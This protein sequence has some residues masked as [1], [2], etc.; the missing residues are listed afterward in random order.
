MII[1][2]PSENASIIQG[3]YCSSIF[4]KEKAV[5]DAKTVAGYWAY[6]CMKH[7]RSEGTSNPQ[8]INNITTAPLEIP[9]IRSKK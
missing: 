4:C 2:Q 8:L 9:W 1:L 3:V 6:L 7:L 5:V